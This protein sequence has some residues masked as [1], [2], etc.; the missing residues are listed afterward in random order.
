[1]ERD[2]LLKEARQVKE[3]MIQEAEKQA[4]EEAGKIIETARLSIENEKMAAIADI[5]DQVAT[6]S[7]E[8]AEKILKQKLAGKED[9]KELIDKLLNEIR[10]N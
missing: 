6:F 4:S 2:G 8:I 7:V 9:Q 10:F 3:K 1:N 5:K